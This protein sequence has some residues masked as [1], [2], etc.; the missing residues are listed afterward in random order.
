[1][2]AQ[3]AISPREIDLVRQR[4]AQLAPAAELIAVL[5]L[6]FAIRHEV[7][8]IRR[9]VGQVAVDVNL[10]DVERIRHEG[11]G[12]TREI[13]GE[14]EIKSGQQSLLD[15]QLA[16]A[17]MLALRGIVPRAAGKV[18]IAPQSKHRPRI[19]R[20]VRG[21]TLEAAEGVGPHL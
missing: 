21:L 9:S 8:G 6:G 10:H 19:D 5:P 2:V 1:V 4:R 7:A 13:P 16:P 17:T 14:L 3:P 20:L 18:G 12:V 11:S 15:E